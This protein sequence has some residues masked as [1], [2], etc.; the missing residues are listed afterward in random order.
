MKM[1]PIFSVIIPTYNT[2]KIIRKTLDSLVGQTY[3]NFEVIVSDDGS[4]DETLSIVREYGAK[5]NLII[6]ENENWGGPARPR[7]LG[8]RAATADWIAFL[9]RIFQTAFCK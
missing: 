4:K 8:I 7:N 6:L 1:K 5:L 2:G 9:A 3:K